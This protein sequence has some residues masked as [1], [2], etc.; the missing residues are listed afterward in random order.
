V[1]KTNKSVVITLQSAAPPDLVCA[2]VSNSI[3]VNVNGSLGLVVPGVPQVFCATEQNVATPT[4]FPMS[5]QVTDNGSPTLTEGITWSSDGDGSIINQ[6]GQ[7]IQYQPTSDEMDAGSTIVFTLATRDPDLGGPCTADT[8]PMTLKINKRAR[9][10]AGD[11]FNSCSDVLIPLTGTINADSGPVT[12]SWSGGGNAS[13]LTPTSPVKANYDASAFEKSQQIPVTFTLTSSDPDSGGPCAAVTDQVTVTLYPKPQVAGIFGFN[14]DPADIPNYQ[15]CVGDVLVDLTTTGQNAEWY[16]DP[17]LTSIKGTGNSFAPAAGGASSAAANN[18]S[19]WV[20]QTAFKDTPG[21]VAGCRSDKRE[22]RLTINPLPVPAFSA[23]NFCLTDDTEFTDA[24]TVAPGRTIT[25]WGWDFDDDLAFIEG[26][27]NVPIPANTHGGVTSGTY[28]NPV[29]VFGDVG[30]YNV[31]LTVTSSDNCKA[32]VSAKD[33]VVPFNEEE[34]RIGAKPKASFTFVKTCDGDD[35]RFTYNGTIPAQIA[36]YDWDFGDGTSHGSGATTPHVFGGVDAYDV[37]LTATTDLGC[38]DVF[39]TTTHILPY[40]KTFPYV[41]NFESPNHG[42]FAEGKVT[43]DG[44]TTSKTSWGLMTSAGAI[45]SDPGQ[46]AG[47]TFWATHTLVNDPNDPNKTYFDNERSVLYGPC[48]DMTELERPVLAMD[49]FSDIELRGDGVYVEYKEEDDDG[50][51]AWVRLGDN[52]SGLNWYN[53]SSIG[54]LSSLSGIGQDVSQF[55]W[56]GSSTNW[57]TGRYNLDARS[58]ATKLRFRIVFGSNQSPVNIDTYDGF[59]LDYFKLEPRNRL[60]L[61]EN[62][63]SAS[64]AN[65]VTGNSTAFKVFPTGSASNEVVKIEYH[66]GLPA[67]T[68]DPQ[69]PIFTQNP[70]DPNARASFYGLSAVPRGYIDGYSNLDGAGMFGNAQGV[71]STWA[72]NYYSTE[73]LKTSPIAIAINNP[74]ITNGVINVTGTVT[75]VEAELLANRYSLYI[76]IVEKTVG[77][78]AYVLRKMLPSA[79]GS[80]VPATAKGASFTFDQSWS[81][82]KTSLG[83]SPELIAIAFVQSDIVNSNN[84]RSILQAAFN[85]NVPVINYTTG[86]EIPFLEQTAVYPNPADKIAT[87]ELPEPTKTGVEVN[88]ID[89]LGR[90]VTRSAIGIGER[91]TSISTSDLSGAVYIVQ[92]KENGVLTTRRLLVTH[93]VR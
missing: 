90:I 76:A 70:M 30:L 87:I 85:D 34:I 88:V 17:S 46:N 19:F 80:K 7:S 33:L 12:V 5:A 60:V 24:S 10:E 47:A 57:T 55:G 41:E 62:F 50:N 36:T 48:V 73:S 61:V 4:V 72:A 25:S 53:E 40:V 59:A 15:K 65:A 64:S 83:A 11:P 18:Y 86:L 54:G 3:T 35:T 22:V 6:G 84:E 66:T 29:H 89:Q 75:A 71:I 1:D 69:D 63:T 77:T 92:L 58:G 2:A 26:G 27:E 68:G 13:G 20:T 81:I 42:W 93:A 21:L 79:S 23:V 31:S 82:D 51:G 32:S 49:Y 74:V 39:T 44:S 91:S 45:L 38:S 43:E 16:A 8:K 14:P 52:T 78:D 9:I 28:N 37:T 56:T 67:Q